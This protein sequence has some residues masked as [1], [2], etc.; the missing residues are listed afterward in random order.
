MEKEYFYLYKDYIDKSIGPLHA[1]K[2]DLRTVKNL[3]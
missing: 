2:C 3:N 1:L